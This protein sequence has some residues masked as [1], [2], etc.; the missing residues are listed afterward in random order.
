[1]NTYEVIP[2]KYLENEQGKKAS[3]YGACPPGYV[4]KTDGYTVRVTSSRGEVTTGLYSLRVPATHRDAAEA[5][6]KAA[7]ATGGKYIP[8]A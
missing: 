1:M 3:I 6:I 4:A 5:A 2:Y 7:S 8:T